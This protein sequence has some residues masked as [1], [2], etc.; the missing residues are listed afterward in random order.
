[1]G[2]NRYYFMENTKKIIT[3]LFIFISSISCKNKEVVQSSDK[4]NNAIKSP[5]LI[6]KT[7]KGYVLQLKDFNSSDNEF[8]TV[9]KITNLKN[10]LVK[11]KD[12]IDFDTFENLTNTSDYKSIVK[13]EYYLNTPIH[14]YFIDKNYVFIYSYL[15][16]NNSFYISGLKKD[17]K[18][19]G[20][21][22][23]KVKDSL[24][25]YG[26]VLTD[27]DL[28][29]F[30]TIDVT[31]NRSEWKATLGIDNKYIYSGNQILTKEV[32]EK[33][34]YIKDSIMKKYYP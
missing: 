14:N 17:L 23:I 8:Y 16:G 33:K 15:D 30:K 13:N 29:S 31:R 21:S 10:E 24:Y 3:I 11:I 2:W 4:K 18:I 20:G 12:I 7:S 26:D 5:N 32:A 34:F 6:I 9:K 27:V 1:M 25:S 22:Y 28:G 19:L